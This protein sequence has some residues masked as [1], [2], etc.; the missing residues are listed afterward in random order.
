MIVLIVTILQCETIPI[1]ES[2]DFGQILGINL[3]DKCQIVM[4][5]ILQ[6][7][8]LCVKII[9]RETNNLKR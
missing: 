4:F 1:I 5:F 8:Y 2:T 7:Q 3:N 6:F 9:Q